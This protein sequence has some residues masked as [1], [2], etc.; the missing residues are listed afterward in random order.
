MSN[1]KT[2]FL[3]NMNIISM[4]TNIDNHFLLIE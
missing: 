3:M 2:Y 1:Y 4:M